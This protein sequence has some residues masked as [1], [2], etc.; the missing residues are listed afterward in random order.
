M[1]EEEMT[2]TI[3]GTPLSPGVAEGII[4]VHRSLLGPIDA[5][6]DIGKQDV[7]EEFSRLDAATS[8]ISD[9]LFALATRVEKEIDTRLAGVFG[10]HQL[11]V[12][13]STLKEELR[14]EIA[15]NLV[16]A[17]SAVKTVFLRWEK[18]FLLMESQIARAKGDDMRDVS[19]RLS[20]ALAGI[21]IHP[22]EEIP[23]GC[24]LATSR[25]LPSDTVFLSGR[26]TAAVLL[27]Y[28]S[29]GS[30]AALFA[31]EMGLPCI[32][33]LH[34]LLAT[35]PD[36]A[37]A[38]VDADT[39][40]VTIRPEE[41]QKI[42]FRKEVDDKQHAY[43][44]IRERAMG[45]A[46]TEDDVAI[47]VLANVSC[48]DDTEK[49]MSNGAE[50]VGLY[51]IERA[52]LGCIVPPN[53]DELLDVMRQTLKAA[54]GHPVCV[55][56]LDIGA[57]KPLPFMKFLAE[58]NPSLGRRGVRYLLEYPELLK[59]HLRALLELS[60]EFDVSV[61]VP[62]VTLPGD[63]AA[64]KECLAQLGSELQIAALPRLGAMIETPAAALSAREIAAHA[65]F[66]SFGT[67][68][69]TQYTFAADRENA[70]VERYFTHSADSIFRLMQIT[71]DDVPDMPLSVCGEIA[72]R[73]KH[74]PRLLQCGIKTFS[75]APPLVPITK[76][77][78]RRSV[79][80]RHI[81]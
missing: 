62:M 38:L 29:I 48:S 51:R 60:R 9:D 81:S 52:Y 30:H 50:G 73:P 12:D 71:H 36:G 65:D 3:Q 68:D 7:E 72:G 2:L 18:R 44:L 17:S 20:N 14:K 69:L 27:E 37:L 64:V 80:G 66:L 5:P 74:I 13:D 53:T 33:G 76:E 10:A 57:D 45:P 19:I 49:A 61:L 24:V 21:T 40:T 22:L 8:R 58:T 41:K 55:R 43:H 42:T 46:V 63:V 16:N 67:N 79:E 15:G 56:L 77:T 32:A 47:S 34:D 25:L 28:G 35:V 6:D 1:S 31:R 26:S 4:H 78:I 75:V 59:T 39:G 11:I 23:H 54:G 70:A